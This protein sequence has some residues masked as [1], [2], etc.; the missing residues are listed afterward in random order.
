MRPLDASSYTASPLRAANWRQLFPYIQDS[1]TFPLIKEN[2]FDYIVVG[3]GTA[4][5]PLAAT[6][7]SKFKVLVLERGGVPYDQVRCTGGKPQTAQLWYTGDPPLG[8]PL[9]ALL[10]LYSREMALE[11]AGG[12]G[13]G[14]CA[15]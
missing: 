11:R 9:A 14:E 1:A 6:L 15:L 13:V 10:T 5:C 12:L 4:G 7:S 3:G 8:W 2:L